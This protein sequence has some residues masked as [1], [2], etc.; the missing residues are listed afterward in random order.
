[1]GVYNSIDDFEAFMLSAPNP[2]REI[3]LKD[4]W[5]RFKLPK[6]DDTSMRDFK[7]EMLT[8]CPHYF[9]APAADTVE[10]TAFY[11]L[12]A[13]AAHVKEF[14]E[15]ATAELLRTEGLTLGR[16]KPAKADSAENIPGAKNPY[17]DQFKGTEEQRQARISSLIKQG[18]TK[19][20]ASLARSSNKTID[21]RPLQTVGRR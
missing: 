15:A 10:H 17:S 14:G 21:G 2:M 7:K 13:Q 4:A 1:M 11:S 3:V 5:P 16:I 8:E 9:A 12:A 20:A 18:G 6:Y 19:L